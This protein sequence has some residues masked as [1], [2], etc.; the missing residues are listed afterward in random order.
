MLNIAY[1]LYH[2]GFN[3]LFFSLEMDAYELHMKKVSM[4]TGVPY[5]RLYCATFDDADI[6]KIDAFEAHEKTRKNEFRVVTQ[7]QMGGVKTSDIER[8]LRDNSDVFKPDVILVDYLGLMTP[9]SM[10]DSER[11]DIGI[12][13][14]CKD[15]RVMGRARGFSTIT[16]AQFKTNSVQRIVQK[17]PENPE[18]ACID[19]SDIA[20][21]AMIGHTADAVYFLWPMPQNKVR[22]IASKV[23]HG[24]PNHAGIDLD[25]NPE[26]QY[27]CDAHAG[28][29]DVLPRSA[30]KP[31]MPV[32]DPA[33][34]A[35][36]DGVDDI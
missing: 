34:T 36:Y 35:R 26:I 28:G 20:E 19:P 8:W 5:Q 11:R 1:G 29:Y 22:L 6:A 21:S 18:K 23:R 2:K 32:I 24:V 30:P 33:P 31:V 4:T 16:A 13:Q 15:F 9:E 7:R 27:I 12:G 25:V 17:Y 14:I 3:V 10:D